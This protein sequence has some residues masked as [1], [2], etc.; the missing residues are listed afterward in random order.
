[1]LFSKKSKNKNLYRLK[2]MAGIRVISEIAALIIVICLPFVLLASGVFA[3]LD[4]VV[5]LAVVLVACFAF[6]LLPAYGFVTWQI[7]INETGITGWSLVKHRKINWGDLKKLTRKSNFNWQRFVLEYE[8]GDLTF[9]LWFERCDELVAEI[10]NHLPADFSPGMQGDRVFKQD[11]ISYLMQI[12]Q[13]CFGLMLAATATYFCVHLLSQGKT[14]LWDSLLVL[15]FALL[16]GLGMFFRSIVVALMPRKIILTNDD[17]ELETI[18][19]RKKIVWNNIV[20][21]KASNPLL[22]EG[23]MLDTKEGSFLIGTGFD[24]LDEFVRAVKEKKSD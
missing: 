8:G 12:S 13:V 19:F 22:P 14:S 5:K 20:E 3:T 11:T 23:F 15:V 4:L 18:F 10:R 6:L 17:L 16:L 1:M 21:L 2:T 9:P 24:A 7:S